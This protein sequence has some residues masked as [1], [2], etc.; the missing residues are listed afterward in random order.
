M[1][2]VLRRIN[3]DVVVRLKW[4]QTEYKGQL[5]SVDSYM[6]IQLNNCV[7]YIDRKHTGDLGQVLIRYEWSCVYWNAHI[8]D[9]VKIDTDF[10]IFIDA[11][12]FSGYL[13][14]KVWKW[15]D[16]AE[17]RRWRNEVS[18]WTDQLRFCFGHIDL[19]PQRL[20]YC[21]ELGYYAS[22]RSITIRM[23]YRS[24]SNIRRRHSRR[25][26]KRIVRL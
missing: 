14:Q 3:E 25:S 9:N 20:K 11:T 5:I 4:G 8:R 13:Q 18:I 26:T 15:M 23:R 2:P 22:D 7:E 24:Y 17:T 12:M 16:R 10:L 1:L 21:Y 19:H 6:N